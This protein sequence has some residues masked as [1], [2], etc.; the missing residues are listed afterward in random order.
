M[1]LNHL[2]IEVFIVVDWFMAVSI[3]S[4]CDVLQSTLNYCCML[5]VG[6]EV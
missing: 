3:A 6:M 2:I 1:T 5:V 4:S